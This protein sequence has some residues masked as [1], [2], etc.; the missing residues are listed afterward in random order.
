MDILLLFFGLGLMLVGIVGSFLP[1]LPGT[2][3]SWVG[4]LLLHL[5]SAV[6]DDW[7]FLGITLAV[8]LLV[9]ALDY[10]IPILGTKKFGGSK[11]GVIGTTIGLLVALIFPILGVL[12][13]IIWPFLGALAGELMNKTNPKTALKAAFGSFL[14]FLAGTFLKF[15][16]TLVFLWLFLA[17]VWEHR[18]PLFPFFKGA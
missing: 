17:K 9:L 8:S 16:V 5:T 4:L 6:P 18:V 7:T 12:G 10:F 14:G 3:L 2:P 13:I 15:M 11:G 1:A